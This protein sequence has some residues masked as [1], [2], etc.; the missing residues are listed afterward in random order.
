MPHVAF[1]ALSGFRVRE[2]SLAELGMSLPGLAGRGQAIAALPPLGLLTLAGMT[3]DPWSMSLHEAPAVTDELV[4]QITRERPTLVAI[5]A[6]TA[7]ILEAYALAR[8]LRNEGIHVVLG[9]LHVT[10]CPD[11]AR[12]H[13]DAIVIS[14]G[15]PTWHAVLADALSDTLKPV[16]QP[17]RPF[18]LADAPLPRFDL[19]GK[20]ERQRYTLQATRGCP[21]ACDF[22]AASRL[23]G[24][25][26]TKPAECIRAEINAIKAKDARPF[27]E[28]A[29]DNTFARGGPHQGMLEAFRDAGARWFTEADWRIGENKPLLERLAESGCVQVLVGLESMVHQ[30]LGM[31]AKLT[32]MPRM[33]DA[34]EA[35]QAAGVAVIG[36]YIVG[37]DGETP[38]SLERLARFLEHDPCADA[39]ITIQTPFP[40]TALRKRLESEGRILPHADWSHH[41]L[42]DVTFQPDRMSVAELE[43]GFRDVV[44]GAFGPE[45]THRRFRIRG[46]TWSRN[47][48][49]SIGR[50]T[51]G[52]D[53]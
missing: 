51:P 18:D 5:S 43:Q 3:P 6:L 44:A 49:L 23:L 32:E 37:S 36:C 10:A 15:E 11:E 22:C 12:Q 35:I 28:L 31:G 29:D 46:E 21:F 45:P 1:V 25:Y 7:S 26:R 33:I 42:F 19:L 50:S 20:S 27:I 8:T 53:R 52:H 24:P 2:E 34:V 16:Y 4:E 14:D 40:G 38:E 30:H 13:A 48:T 17:E 41:T 39:Q 47:P 9:G